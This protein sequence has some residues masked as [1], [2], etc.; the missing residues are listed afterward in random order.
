MYWPAAGSSLNQ[1]R[2]ADQPTELSPPDRK[3]WYSLVLIL[4]IAI[5][6]SDG[7]FLATRIE[8]LARVVA[9]DRIQPFVIA[10]SVDETEPLVDVI[11]VREV[12]VANFG[13]RAVARV[14]SA[15]ADVA[16]DAETDTV[17][18]DVEN[19]VQETRVDEKA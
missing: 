18:G 13:F 15:I 3:S 10:S 6:V 19:H 14:D 8:D 1:L 7:R 16:D 5:D 12:V 2:V 17:G 4:A 9:L 11:S